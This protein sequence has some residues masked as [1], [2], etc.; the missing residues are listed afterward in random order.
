VSYAIGID[1]GTESGRAVLVD[2]G[3]G[4]ELATAVHPYA[5]GVIDERLP[6]PDEDVE[7]EAD[8]A[9]Q[10]PDDYVAVY[11]EAVPALLAETGVDAGEVIGIGIDFTSC[12]MLPTT[13]DGT[14]LC[15]LPEL[16]R[17]PH[18]WV[19]L[20][21]HHAAQ[22]EADRIN[23]VAAERGERWLPR[24]G[25]KISSEWF[26][27][28]SLQILLEAPEVYARADRLIEAADWAVW[29]LTGTETR[30]S[31]TA[32]YK[33]MWSKRDGFPASS[34]FA[35]LDP[36]FANVVDEK[37][38]RA[39]TPLG[40]RAGGL[41]EQA[42][43]W[44]GLLSGTAVA[45]ANVDAHVSA[46]AATVTE[47]GTMV[48]IMGTSICHILLG[49][50]PADVEGMCGVVEDGVVPGLF[51]FEAGQSAVGDIFAWFVDSCVPPE[52]HE[53]AAR[54]GLDVHAYLEEEAAKLEPGESGL[55][56]LDWWNGNR[57]VL[58]DA[59]LGG[60]LVGMTLQT[61]APELYR[62]LIE[63][64]AFGTRVIVDAFRSAGVTVD[65]MVACGGLPERNKLLM[66]IYADVT[67]LKHAV[68][69]SRQT[70]ALGAAMFGA[71][72]A[73]AARGGY[74]SI[75]E[76]SRS[77]AQLSGEVFRPEPAAS[78]VYEQLYPE[79]V[80]L[81]DVFG[82]GGND[83]MKSLRSIRASAEAR[84]RTRE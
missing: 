10:D 25:G 67:G 8:W 45:V 21:K 44:T 79:Y 29:Q 5:N 38:S 19:K 82:R 60:L 76:A 32:G 65:R 49:R 11:R 59:D 55:L 27:A 48:A 26:M 39:I 84:R 13:A 17:N 43:A 52:E 14:P 35:A 34:Y 30:N 72:A 78:A 16:R 37:M 81:H 20:W 40:T 75:V 62:A 36:R 57:S 15:R 74:D 53:A 83:V 3:D 42:A 24:Y 71:V 6:A 12:T 66:Q 68:A 77:M 18:A 7:L 50:E 31:C 9:L 61:R 73:G 46:P 63:A 1:F 64:T 23:A 47:P 33:A 56:A 28:K 22:P 70:P 2:C 4:R 69:A 80:R 54:R 58:V 41:S 51:G